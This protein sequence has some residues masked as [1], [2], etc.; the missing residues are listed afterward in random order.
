LKLLLN[1]VFSTTPTLG[2]NFELRDYKVEGGN[3]RNYE[4][5]IAYK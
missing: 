5:V 2:N 3:F 4:T 1:G